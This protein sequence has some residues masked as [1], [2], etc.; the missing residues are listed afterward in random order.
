M[1]GVS[2]GDFKIETLPKVTYLFSRE[3]L[4]LIKK[5]FNISNQRLTVQRHNQAKII[6]KSLF[7]F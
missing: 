2:S 5:M 1:R 3:I 4:Y 6:K 7:L